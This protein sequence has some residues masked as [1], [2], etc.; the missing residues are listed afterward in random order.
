MTQAVPYVRGSTY[1]VTGADPAEEAADRIV[2][3]LG[4]HVTERLA[5]GLA[6]MVRSPL[7]TIAAV[8]SSSLPAL[9]ARFQGYLGVSPGQ[10]R[11]VTEAD[12]MV[13]I[14]AVADPP[15]APLHE[16]CAL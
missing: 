2:A 3:V 8:A 12:G 1:L 6:A 5:R 14:R 13:L 7:V 15:S 9:D 11:A 10:I 16:S 4:R